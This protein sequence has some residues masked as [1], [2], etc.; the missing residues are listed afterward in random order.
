MLSCQLANVGINVG[1]EVCLNV[2]ELHH[3]F[4]CMSDLVV[5]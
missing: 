3:V 5:G 2:I 4:E 1:S